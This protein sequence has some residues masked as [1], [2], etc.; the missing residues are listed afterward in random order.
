MEHIRVDVRGL[1]V[2]ERPKVI[3]EAFDRLPEGGVLT[4]VTD[5]EPRGLSESLT[6]GRRHELVLE[7]RRVGEREWHVS[8]TRAVHADGDVQCASAVLARCPAFAGLD[9]EERSRLASAAG[10]HVLR[11]GQQ[12]IG[13]NDDWPYVGVV[14]DGVLA[15]SNGSSGQR[16]RI[17][18]EVF[19]NEV[20]GETEFFDRS[21]SLGRV[22][23]LSKSA[24]VVRIPRDV[25]MAVGMRHPRLLVDLAIVCAQRIRNL[26]Q[27]L[28][29]Q[30]AT[31]IIA[32]IA[33]ALLPYAMPER[34]LSPATQ[35]LASVTQAQIAASAGTVKEV[36]A[37]AIAELE[38]RGLLKRERGHI[39]F[40]DRQGLVDLIREMT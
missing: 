15:I 36:A 2:W 30:A 27:A 12:I 3:F 5:N 11:R 7:P 9:D 38:S 18:T 17:L 34:G 8:V 37:R 19:S 33:Q 4:F 29:A 14:A 23:V 24:R 22:T 31:P 13:E 39:R 16:E 40:L 28:N 6:Q 25:V 32:R 21:P 35:T 20:F 10:T 26:A 1:P